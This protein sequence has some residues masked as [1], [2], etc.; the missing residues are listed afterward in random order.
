MS[1]LFKE[2]EKPSIPSKYRC[3]LSDKLMESPV[4]IVGSKTRAAYNEADL[5]KYWEAQGVID[6]ETDDAIDENDLMPDLALKREIEN[7]VAKQLKPHEE[8]FSSGPSFDF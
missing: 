7:F 3:A 6:P 5:K 1:S 4:R 2:T 8:D